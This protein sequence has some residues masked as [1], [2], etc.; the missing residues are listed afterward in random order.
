M[1]SLVGLRIVLRYL[2]AGVHQIMVNVA[3]IDTI[4]L[5]PTAPSFLKHTLSPT[6]SYLPI[7]RC[8]GFRGHR[9]RSVE[10]GDARFWVSYK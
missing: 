1:K 7:L 3:S 10:V 2:V 6:L 4:F 5:M 8:F 9:H